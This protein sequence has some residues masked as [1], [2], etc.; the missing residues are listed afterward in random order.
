M[1]SV[2]IAGLGNVFL[3]DDAFGVEVVQRLR[4][5]PLPEGVR[6]EDFGIRGIDLTYALLDGAG[7]AILVDATQRG[8]APGTLYVIEPEVI[9][10][11]GDSDPHAMLIS[12]HEMD[13]GKVLKAVRMLD[14]AC[15]HIVLVGC[16]PESF[17]GEGEEEGRMGLSE[18][19]SAAVDKAVEIIES[20]AQRL[21]KRHEAIRVQT[22]G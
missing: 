5:R 6:V 11:E 10:G 21:V 22:E 16:E 18:P 8:G 15:E 12:P 4:Q 1:N 14:G 17:G 13:P 9:E 19:V 7:A 3:G 20:L 2:L